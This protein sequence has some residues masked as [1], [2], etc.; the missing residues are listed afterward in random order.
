MAPFCITLHAQWANVSKGTHVHVHIFDM[1]LETEC[2][3]HCFH[4][5]LYLFTSIIQL[6]IA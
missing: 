5:M 4:V 6:G 3:S 2:A 1:D